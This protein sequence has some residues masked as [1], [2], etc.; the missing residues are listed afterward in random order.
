MVQVRALKPVHDDGRVDTLLWLQQLQADTRLPDTQ[1]LLEACELAQSLRQPRLEHGTIDQALDSYVTGLE[2]AEIL[3]TLKVDEDTLVAAILYRSVWENKLSLEQVRQQFSTS[4]AELIHGVLQMAAISTLQHP[5]RDNILGQADSQLANVRKMLVSLVD[6][7]RLALIKL[8]ERTCAIREVKHANRK[9]RYL[10]SRE[11]FDVYAPLAHRLGIGSIK[12]ELEDLSFRYL[13]PNAYKQIASLLDERRLDRQ[14]YIDSILH[15]VRA[16][17]EKVGIQAQMMGRAKH[18]YSIWRK[19]QRKNID[20]SQVYDTRAVRIL[21]PGDTDCYT[22]LGVV[23]ALW[24]NIPNEFD[25]YIATP[26]ENGYRSLHTAVIGPQGK[27]VEVQI[28]TQ[29]M[30][31]EAELG[32]CAHWLYKGADTQH[33][34]RSYEDKL[35]WLRQVLEWHEEV[36][37]N[38][39][40][41]DQMRNDVTQDR[42]YVFTPNGHVVDLPYG[43]TPVDFAY[44]VHTDVG[45]TCRG[46]KVH[47]RI[48]PLTIRLQTGDQVNILTEKGGKPSRDW[49]NPNLGYINTSRARAKVAYWFK[50]QDKDKNTAAGKQLIEREM[51]RLALTEVDYNQLCI[52]VNFQKANDMYAALGAGDLGLPQVINAAQAQ[53]EPQIPASQPKGSPK[54][55]H[56]ARHHSNTSSD[57]RIAGVGNLMTILATCCTPLPGDAIAGYITLNRGI[58][59]HRQ[60]CHN[61][62]NLA[63]CHG[64]RIIEVNWEDHSE[65]TYPVNIVIQVID[66][67]G[68]LR[69]VMLVLGDEKV[70]V[71]SINTVIDKKSHSAIIHLTIDIPRLQL[72][73]RVMDKISQLPNVLDVRRQK[74]GH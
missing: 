1:R 15:Q 53:L 28:R 2:M 40:F 67:T 29:A 8:A 36:D 16:E 7:V 54:A 9:H 61:I 17:L 46:A 42:V 18:I 3:A 56:V 66:R 23:H 19:M 12:W 35:A 37:D 25:D 14:I 70:N 51:R 24:C 71:I 22:A 73:G 34:S 38:S 43:A 10:V 63:K 31:D 65:R 21:V 32:V 50:Q 41:V 69:D 45:N 30:H 57:V 68:L 55:D 27:V 44:R 60:D 59:V 33:S 20:F 52:R 64:Q 11:V 26:K 74:H 48:V 47:G 13:Q 4:I 72:L 6:D 39:E 5:T 58:S 62:M 49:L